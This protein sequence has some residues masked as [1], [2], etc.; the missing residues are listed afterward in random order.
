MEAM[1]GISLC[2]CLYPKLAKIILSLMFSLQQNLRRGQ[3]RFCLEVRGIRGED[4][5][6]VSRGRDR[7]NNV[8]THINK[9]INNKKGRST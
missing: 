2:T 9:L 4:V 3:N 5:D 6:W 1:L 7:P 8:Y